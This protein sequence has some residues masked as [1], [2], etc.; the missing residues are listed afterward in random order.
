MVDSSFELMKIDDFLVASGICRSSDEAKSFGSGEM[1]RN[2]QVNVW[3]AL[4]LIVDED[5]LE[6]EQI[7]EMHAKCGSFIDALAEHVNFEEQP[8][9]TLEIN[10]YH[11]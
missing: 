9:V 6:L 4:A 10:T 5:N 7:T 11:F 2:K 8:K 3:Q 1:S